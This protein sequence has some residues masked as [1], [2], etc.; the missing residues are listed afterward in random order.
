[1]KRINNAYFSSLFQEGQIG[2]LKVK[3]RIV[4]LPTRNFPSAGNEVSDKT[5]THYVDR[6]K[7]GFGLLIVGAVDIGLSERSLPFLSLG[8]S[9]FIPGHCDLTEAVHEH[10]ARIAAQLIVLGRALST[11]Q[12][13][14]GYPISSS[15]IPAVLLGERP[16]PTPRSLE[17]SEIEGLMNLYGESAN[18][19]R[20]A[21]YDM[22]EIHACHGMLVNSFIS[23]YMNKRT[24]E[25]GGSIENRMRFVLGI[26][27][28]IRE[29]V[30]QDFPISIRI[31]ADEFVEGG[32]SIK[33]SPIIAKMLKKG[34]ASVINISAG[35]T[36]TFHK[37][38]DMMR[39]PEGG[40]SY[41]WEAIKSA[42]NIPT[43]AGGNL[44]GPEICEEMIRRRKTDFVGLA[45]ASLA[46]PEWPKKV[47]EGRMEDLCKCISCNECHFGAGGIP[48]RWTARCTVNPAWGR[49]DKFTEIKSA[50]APKQVMIV[51][52][53]P[54]GL[55]AARV[56]ALRGHKVSLF[57]KNPEL[58]GRLL[59]ASKP[60]HKEKMLWFLNYLITQ[61]KK[62]KVNV[63][64]NTNVEPALVEKLNPDVVII[65]T[66][67]E[68]EI[69]DFP[70]AN[71]PR[72]I[73]AEDILEGKLK[74]Q[75]QT[76]L[77]IG[78]NTK[79]CETA[80]FLTE[81]NNK[82]IIVEASPM[83][84]PEMEPLNRKGLMDSLLEKGACIMTRSR[85]KGIFE[86]KVVIVDCKEGKGE[87]KEVDWVV[88]ALAGR[89]NETFKASLAERFKEV[90][91][92]GDCEEPMGLMRAVY[93]GSLVARK[94]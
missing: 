63:I 57:E 34:G 58:G 50:V 51:G 35:I 70:G 74:P 24:D 77:I 18:R 23:P 13:K 49:G 94:I 84:A 44:R 88:L 60:P 4:M 53:G 21:G 25:F 10:G 54:A 11:I 75:N 72:V 45:R 6:A 16:F 32:I 76:I 89:S 64:L 22:V 38:N 65:A 81:Q 5:I 14:G 30:G 29:K 28:K 71:G 85:V 86:G 66:G 48:R 52:G 91:T 90:Y 87:Q 47:L 68:P 46:D 12:N 42:V 92:I 31:S 40:R 73:T 17:K 26:I 67:T 69:P 15:A 20:A 37:C 1:M 82:V 62:L 56:G 61:I 83:L 19:A 3:N 2:T 79:G 39:L 78:G 9:R 80:E 59:L 33:E 93:E 43:I 7:G 27:R 55:E 36:E 8:E 41:I